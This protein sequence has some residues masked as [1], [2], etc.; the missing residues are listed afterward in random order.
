LAGHQSAQFD[1]IAPPA[2]GNGP[3]A[4][5]ACTARISPAVEGPW[6]VSLTA[7]ADA[8]DVAIDVE[9]EFDAK[10]LGSDQ[11]FQRSSDLARH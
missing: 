10:R 11:R 6:N 3:H 2:A 4:A 9:P 7:N 5:I 1:N 8:F